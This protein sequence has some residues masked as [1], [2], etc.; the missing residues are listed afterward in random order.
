MAQPLP[1]APKGM[2]TMA[3]TDN[4]SAFVDS[5]AVSIGLS[6]MF[7]V[8]GGSTDPTYLVLTLL[9][10]NEYTVA[11]SG[12]TGSLSGDGNTLGFSTVGGDGRGAGIV[13]TYTF[14]SS[15]D[16]YGY[17]NAT[18]GWFSQLTYNSSSSSNDVTNL[19][20]FGT[21]NLAIATMAPSSAN[22]MMEID[23]SGYM[24][25]ATVVTQPGYTATVPAQATPDSIAAAADSF[26]GQAWNLNGCWVLASTIAAEAGASL[27]VQSTLVG[28]SGQ[29]SGSSPSTVRPARPAIG[30]TWSPPAR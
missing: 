25:S 30:R 19:S 26:I 12:A 11:A 9:D 7:T 8:T 10:R 23:P 16:Q 17:Y 18:Y 5:S 29:A 6:Q 22:L 15:T 13:F 24:G 28:L 21:N 4:E 20:L 14:D 3:S 27:P 2:R 1:D